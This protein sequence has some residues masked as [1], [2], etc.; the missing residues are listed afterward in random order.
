MQEMQV[1]T[2]W[3]LKKTT[4]TRARGR[5]KATT[6]E[7][8][9]GRLCEARAFLTDTAAAPVPEGTGLGHGPAARPAHGAGALSSFKNSF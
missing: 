1:E 4:C 7:Q 3:S 5:G 6:A 9:R 8:R 2:S